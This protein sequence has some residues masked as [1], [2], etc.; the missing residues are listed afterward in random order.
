MFAKTAEA[1]K[2]YAR[3]LNMT[4]LEKKVYEACSNENWGTS[5][6]VMIELAQSTNNFADYPVIV[7]ETCLAIEE[8]SSK[9]RRILKGLNL[10]E[11]LIKFGNERV[12]EDFRQS[13][14]L[15]KLRQLIDLRITEEGK[16]RGASI[17]EKATLVLNLLNDQSFLRSEREKAGQGRERFVGVESSGNIK[18]FIQPVVSTRG[19]SDSRDPFKPQQQVSTAKLDAIRSENSSVKISFGS[20]KMTKTNVPTMDLL[21][22][23]L[24]PKK[25]EDFGDFVSASTPKTIEQHKSDNSLNFLF[26]PNN[27]FGGQNTIQATTSRRSSNPFDFSGL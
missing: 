14:R 13:Y 22:F 27:P 26:E 17:R 20:P 23:E 25:S 8:P 7:G 6:S 9:W 4:P 21:D 3:K 10:L 5:N 15:Q 2:E 19:V 11:Y 24:S 1:F 12:L 16:D 18:K